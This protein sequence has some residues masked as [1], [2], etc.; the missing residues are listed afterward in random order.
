MPIICYTIII[1]IVI[2]N[3]VYNMCIHV[4]TTH[5]VAVVA[6]VVPVVAVVVAVVAVWW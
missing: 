3:K 6:V 1:I 2:D 5:P 4:H